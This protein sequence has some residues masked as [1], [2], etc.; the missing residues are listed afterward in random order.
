MTN[1]ATEE[2]RPTP[3][4]LSER[5]RVKIVAGSGSVSDDLYQVLLRRLRIMIT[6]GCV[7]YVLP[8]LLDIQSTF[9]TIRHVIRGETDP[10]S[11]KAI[12]TVYYVLVTL[13]FTGATALLWKKPPATVQA[14]RRLELIAIGSVVLGNLFQMTSP[15]RW[16]LLTN[17]RQLPTEWRGYAV[18]AH[19]VGDAFIWFMTIIVYGTIIPNTWRRCALVVGVMA[20]SPIALFAAMG[21]WFRPIEAFQVGSHVFIIAFYNCFAV[22]IVAFSSSR[23]EFL[24]RQVAEARKLG[25]YVLKE[26]LGAGGMGEV[27]R[28]EHLLLRRPCAIKLIRPERTGDSKN[29]RRFEREVQMTATLTHPNTIQIYDYGRAED[30]TFY[31]VME[32]L[33]GLNLE[34]LV[35]QYGPLSPER[36]VHLL[37]QVCGALR[38]AHAAGLIHRDIKPSNVIVCQ[39]GGLHDVAKLLDFSIVE[40]LIPDQGTEITA[41][42]QLL[43]TPAYMSPEQA[44][45]VSNLDARS[46]LASLGAT[47]Y[48]M[49]TGKPPFDYPTMNL[50]I[51]AQ[52][53]DAVKPPHL[54]R[55]EIPEDLSA[56]IVRCLE[57]DPPQRFQDAA[58]LEK[59][60]SQCV[61]AGQWTEERAVLASQESASRDENSR[62]NTAELERRWGI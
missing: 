55:A 6:I 50:V 23:I 59:A 33:H 29:L 5:V 35:K 1:R 60:L 26:Q 36:T 47:A 15:E 38:E 13:L 30:G 46:D 16:D 42:G 44:T 54:L 61:C 3:D 41:H 62:L 18:G 21:L 10:T 43:G 17:Y 25:Q 57:K 8:A 48:F 11:F 40:T 9:Q 34:Q 20:I 32:Y 12:A 27:Y 4:A 31:Y 51:T 2:Y 58:A 45:G 52:I 14:L 7:Y 19:L 39:R 22:A 28:A 53:R 56:V 49:L 24:R 37:R